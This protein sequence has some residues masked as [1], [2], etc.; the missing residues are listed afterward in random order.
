M[1]RAGAA[2]MMGLGLLVIAVAAAVG[3]GL[4]V[5]E[6]SMGAAEQGAADIACTDADLAVTAAT[7][8]PH[9]VNFTVENTGREALS[10]VTAKAARNGSIVGGL[11][12]GTLDAGTIRS[13]GM[14]TGERATHLRVAASECPGTEVVRALG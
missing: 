6:N 8:G 3:A 4:A 2:K 10:D 14:T 7:A 11:L 5:V 12:V 9:Q 13:I 1:R